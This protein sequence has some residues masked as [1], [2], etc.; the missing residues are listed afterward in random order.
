MFRLVKMVNLI[1]A[2]ADS[3]YLSYLIQNFSLDIYLHFITGLS[4]ASVQAA[5]RP[6]T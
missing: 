2:K 1:T 3:Y 5:T 4:E 6:S